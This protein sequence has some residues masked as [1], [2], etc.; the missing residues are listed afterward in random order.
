MTIQQEV[1]DILA[2]LGVSPSATTNGTLTVRTPITGE[3]IARLPILTPDQTRKA[4]AQAHTAF[5][6]WRPIPAPKQC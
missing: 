6:D 2:H 5:L 1:S 3:V 4:T